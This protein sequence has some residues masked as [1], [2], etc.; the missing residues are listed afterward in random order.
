ML[1]YSFILN[2]GRRCITQQKWMQIVIM[3]ATLTISTHFLSKNIIKLERN[4]LRL[5]YTISLNSQFK[6]MTKKLMV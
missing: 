1:I 6:L 2:N 5:K 4:A 3:M